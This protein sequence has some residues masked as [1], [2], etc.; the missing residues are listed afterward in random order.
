VSSL[1]VCIL[2]RLG[3]GED[4]WRLAVAIAK[5]QGNAWANLV[6]TLPDAPKSAPTPK[7]EDMVGN[8]D[9]YLEWANEWA[10]ALFDRTI[11]THMHGDDSLAL[12]GA[13]EITRINPRIETEAEARKVPR[14]VPFFS[15]GR[16]G[17]PPYLAFLEPVA[18][19]L[20]DQER[21]NNE[22]ARV[23]VLERGLDKMP[24]QVARVVALV[25]DLEFVSA[26]QNGQPGWVDFVSEPVAN[27][28]RNEGDAAVDALIE[29]LDS[30]TRLTRSVG[31]G[32]SFHQGRSLVDVK[33]VARAI[34]QD[35]LHKSFPDADGF[36]R[37]WAVNKGLSLQQRWY[38]QLAD[39]SAGVG[40]WVEATSWIVLPS[41]VSFI[42][43]A[44]VT[45][46]NPKA[47]L[48]GESLRTNTNPTVAEL[49]AKRARETF[50]VRLGEPD[51]TSKLEN[52]GGFARALAIW[53]G[54]AANELLAW[55]MR[56]CIEF[57]TLSN[58]PVAQLHTIIA[59]NSRRRADAGDKVA[60][61][62]YGA[63]LARVPREQVQGTW[64]ELAEPLWRFPEHPGLK[65]GGQRLFGEM[66]SIQT[67]LTQ[68]EEFAKPGFLRGPALGIQAVQSQLVKHLT[69][70]TLITVGYGKTNR[71]CEHIALVLAEVDGM[72]QF[73]SDWPMDRQKHA[74]QSIALLMRQYGERF[75]YA[76]KIH[77]FKDW[78]E[79]KAGMVFPKLTKPATRKQVASGQAIFSL[80][81]Q[82]KTR[83]CPLP[84]HPLGARWV[85]LMDFPWVGQAF[86]PRTGQ[87]SHPTNYYQDGVVW[88]AEEVRINGKWERFY[89]FVGKY[90]I[91]KVPA[92]DIN[93]PEWNWGWSSLSRGLDCAVVAPGGKRLGPFFTDAAFEW[94]KPVQL[95]LKLRNRSGLD[96]FVPTRYGNSNPSRALKSG[97][98]MRL[99]RAT[100]NAVV[101][102]LKRQGIGRVEYWQ[103][104]WDEVKPREIGKFATDDATRLLRPAEAFEAFE[105]DLA[106]W[107]VL[108]GPGD[109]L[110]ALTF[111]SKDGGVADGSSVDSLFSL[112]TAT[113]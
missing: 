49:F 55:Q 9:P 4:A 13:R 91:A 73:S 76:P 81:G 111:S 79:L 109:Y 48:T 36:R 10:W 107:F 100:D 30:D 68:S 5:S 17:V 112:R 29:C 52:A 80:E 94:G 41:N 47:G 104:K 61:N 2:L 69:N 16:K 59:R 64:K 71:V 58:A 75:R 14:P 21:R 83:I 97:I 96:Q 65:L 11:W 84:E 34:L 39:D 37:Y 40:A 106:D 88:Q 74:F 33:T 45:T 3:K 105:W 26:R 93:F 38:H 82:G 67:L 19:L 46:E 7:D 20:A 31:F 23:P 28:L 66:I 1:K 42:S 103:R 70:Q 86:D 87:S 113:K 51:T 102:D 110:L 85:T 22:P 78:F 12:L 50:P 56:R 18:A 43:G 27:A 72:P 53:A 92:A 98:T 95:I 54:P 25:K 6:K 8:I 44:Q 24:D 99:S 32:R 108:P 77:E 89:G 90:T 57:S 15:D 101:S 60:L 35:I 62:E 63:W